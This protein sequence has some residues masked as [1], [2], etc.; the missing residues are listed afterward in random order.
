MAK[1][2]KS[3]QS[4]EEISG[5]A[6]AKKP[7]SLSKKDK[8]ATVKRVRTLAGVE[9]SNLAAVPPAF[10]TLS[11]DNLSQGKSWLGMLKGAIRPKSS[12][13]D[14]AYMTIGPK[15]GVF[16]LHFEPMTAGSPYLLD[17]EVATYPE[18]K[19]I[20]EV[21]GAF[22]GVIEDQDGHLLIGF[23]AADKAGNLALS[24]H[25]GVPIGHLFKCELTRVD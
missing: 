18:G 15:E 8:E 12:E 11:P 13:K 20:W 1:D 25:S 19:M 4:F 21:H 17:C 2:D 22:N 10:I 14:A 24:R 5:K 16:L 23:I 7:A 3:D 6:P 9:K